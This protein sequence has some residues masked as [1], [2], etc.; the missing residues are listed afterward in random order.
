MPEVAFVS[1][2]GQ[3]AWLRE[4]AQTI[5]HEL[6]RQAVD[7]THH[8]GGFPEVRPDRVYVL[9]DPPSYLMGEGEAIAADDWQLRRTVALWTSPVHDDISPAQR[10]L[11]EQVGAVFVLDQ[12]DLIALQ[13][14]GFLPRLLR[15]GYSSVL[16][17]YD[18]GA[19]RPIDAVF[20]GCYSD[21][22][23]RLL[24]DAAPVL[25]RYDTVIDLW[26]PDDLTDTA[27]LKAR[28][29]LLAAAKV[30]LHLHMD[31]DPRIEWPA[32]LDAVHAGAAVV[33]E[34][35]SGI[36]P[37]EVGEHLLVSS[38]VALPF[39]VEALIRDPARHRC[40]AAQ[41]YIR[42][43][44]WIPFALPIAV[45]RAAVVEL[46]GEPTPPGA[47]F[48]GP[49]APADG[50]LE[51]E[52]SVAP[53]RLPFARMAKGDAAPR[54]RAVILAADGSLDDTRNSLSASRR[55]VSELVQVDDRDQ[56]SAAASAWDDMAP[57]W[58]LV[59]AGQTL[60][61]HG[62]EALEAALEADPALDLVHPV[63]ASGAPG[64]GSEVLRGWR[65]VGPDCLE[66]PALVRGER[67][68]E[69]MSPGH[70]LTAGHVRSHAA[71]AGWRI[72]QVPQILAFDRLIG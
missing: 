18:E 20:S 6:R 43:R 11:L 51:E 54:V 38:P 1:S 72:G 29:E 36:A 17:R 22:R 9:L 71:R 26:H 39:V 56:E 58:L 28:R 64:A 25:A 59:E 12:R 4:L 69:L 67:A 47:G 21:R 16:D 2:H 24:A 3:A 44:D 35:A 32:V 52:D 8:L 66:F 40:Q 19:S 63:V 41:A 48:A 14:M 10:A 68:A 62:L 45:L 61:P 70:G 65:P 27:R 53:L 33:T 15:P 37:L 30:S 42:L 46:V 13:R 49:S 31:D 55:R 50:S 34:Q 23:A 7:P 60:H 5:A 57:L